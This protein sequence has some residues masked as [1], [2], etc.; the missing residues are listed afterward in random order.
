MFCCIFP[1]PSSPADYCVQKFFLKIGWIEELLFLGQFYPW[2]SLGYIRTPIMF[3]RIQFRYPDLNCSHTSDDISFGT[4]ISRKASK[5]DANMF[6]F[7]FLLHTDGISNRS[8][9]VWLLSQ[10]SVGG[11]VHRLQFQCVCIHLQCIWSIC[12]DAWVPKLLVSINLTH[13]ERK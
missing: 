1:T 2:C 9:V 3:P 5:I 12:H 8:D 10:W 4:P 6:S 13:A 11:P 7:C